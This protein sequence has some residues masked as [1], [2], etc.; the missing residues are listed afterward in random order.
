MDGLIWSAALW[1]V[2]LLIL[3]VM[4]SEA[5]RLSREQ[6][7][8]VVV[9]L[10]TNSTV[11]RSAE[12][13][14]G[15]P[16]IGETLIRGALATIALVMVAPLVLARITGGRSVS[17]RGMTALTAYALIAALSTAYSVAP[18]STAGKAYE[19]GVA[20]LIAWAIA[21]RRDGRSIARQTLEILVLYS[22]IQVT[23][24]V[25]GFF[26]AP[27]L[28]AEVQSRTPFIGTATMVSPYSHSNGLS[29]AGA[30]LSAYA[31][32]RWLGRAQRVDGETSA[33]LLSSRMWAALFV[34]GTLGTILASARQGLVIWI[35]SVTV[36]LWVF[37]RRLLLLTLPLGAAIVVSNWDVV[38]AI[39][40]RNQNASSLATW[41]GRLLYWQS[42]LEA[43]S[44][45]P[46]LGFGFGVGGR[47]VAL[48]R[49][50]SGHISSVHSGYVEALMGVGLLGI[51]PLLYAIWSAGRWSLARLR[52]RTDVALG[53]LIAPLALHTSVSLGFGGWLTDS[54]V[55]FMLLVVLSDLEGP[56]PPPRIGRRRGPTAVGQRAKLTS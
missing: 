49:I 3:R 48:L 43:L 52:S 15:N 45:H 36:V 44:D 50:G 47:F 16:L 5:A 10:G 33:S 56:R 27:S 9:L 29:A 38:W 55:L 31:I 25:V 23:I 18:V 12:A 8:L 11:S 4:G 35:V 37:R 13:V 24:A 51:V 46:F 42:G 41:S 53:A 26:A 30:M 40:S 20:L 39:V 7:A 6:W 22:A 32:A 1:G 28:F 2:L 19:I 21:L 14:L 54:V 34:T 17:F